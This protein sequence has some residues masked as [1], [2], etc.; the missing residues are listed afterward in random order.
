MVCFLPHTWTVRRY[1][2]TSAI[3]K[4]PIAKIADA[5]GRFEA[6][7]V[8]IVLYFAGHVQMAASQNV[9]TFASAQVCY[10]A[11]SQGLQVLQQIF[12]A[13]TS[14]LLNRALLFSLPD[15]P[16]LFTVWAGPKLAEMLLVHT[17][18][19][20]GYGIWTVI[21]PIAFLPLMLALHLNYKKAKKM[22]LLTPSPKEGQSLV[23]L[24]RNLWYDL[25]IM[26][27][28]L[29]CAA[30]ALILIP[31]TIAAKAASKWKNASLIA[32][33]SIG[34][35]CLVIFPFWEAN[36]RLAPQPFIP[37]RLLRNRSVLAGC[38]ISF[39]YFAVFYTSIQ[40]YFSSYLQVVHSQSVTAAG[41]IVNLFSL[42]STI[43]GLLISLVIKYTRHYK[44]YITLGAC[45][46]L[47]GVGLMI[48]F[49]S[50]DSSIV[51]IVW[52]QICIGFG[53]GLLNVPTQLGVQ[54]SVGHADVAAATA[55][56]LTTLE[57]GGAVGGAISGAIWSNN[58]LP[59]LQSYLPQRSR[60]SAEIIFGNITLAKSFAKGSLESVAIDR[61][62][63]ESL[64]MILIVAAS[65]AAPLIPLSL[66]MQNYRLD[67]SDRRGSSKNALEP[68]DDQVADADGEAN[69]GR[70]E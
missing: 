26:G 20:W 39:L 24:A 32:M 12:I 54:A 33:T 18:W 13:D 16:F 31:L 27:L 8:T 47:L 60:A 3:V 52:T 46:Y 36:R 58:L 68:Q 34:A 14:T 66:C 45:V 56:F 6:F 38:S 19:R 70:N 25:D 2:Q 42:A 48:Q 11:G 35:L 55:A 17:G 62:Y 67:D 30:L 40:P 21:L 5:F 10:S 7:A 61:S 43:G 22:N 28:V 49:R 44:Y 59:K 4:P 64:D 37:L 69:V 53:C 15:V 41:Q 29:L 51:A 23:G 9:G 65:F 63:Q 1:Q 50:Q 57:I